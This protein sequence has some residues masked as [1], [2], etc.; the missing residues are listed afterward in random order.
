VDAAALTA[1]LEV[2]RAMDTPAATAALKVLEATL[3]P[4][5]APTK[6]PEKAIGPLLRKRDKKQAQLDKQQEWVAQ[7]EQRLAEAKAR[8]AEISEKLQA[9]Q[10]EL[11]E[12]RRLLADE[13]TEA[14]GKAHSTQNRTPSLGRER[15]EDP[16]TWPTLQQ[17]RETWK[18][19][20]QRK[21]RQTGPAD[22]EESGGQDMEGDTSGGEFGQEL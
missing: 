8:E 19:Q 5:A 14:E 12:V 18:Q 2:L 17:Q 13:P 6:D 1:C 11:S 10:E 22:G 20:R 16:G 15:K 3:G 4:A 9:L 7:C 21:R